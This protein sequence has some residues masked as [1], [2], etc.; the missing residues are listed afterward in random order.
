MKCQNI[1]YSSLFFSNKFWMEGVLYCYAF[2]TKCYI[3]LSYI[4]YNSM[5]TLNGGAERQMLTP[6]IYCIEAP[7]T[8]QLIKWKCTTNLMP[9]QM[10]ANDT[11]C[12]PENSSPMALF[13]TTGA[14]CCWNAFCQLSFSVLTSGVT[15]N[16]CL[17]S[18]HQCC[19]SLLLT[20]VICCAY[21]RRCCECQSCDKNM[22]VLLVKSTASSLLAMKQNQFLWHL[23]ITLLPKPRMTAEK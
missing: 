22:T 10:S 2:K 9:K 8:F 11:T 1:L 20:N 23:L 13:T 14:S 16:L 7:Q 21:G 3:L 18:Q 15:F 6:C 4:I 5:E 17:E 12:S 19:K